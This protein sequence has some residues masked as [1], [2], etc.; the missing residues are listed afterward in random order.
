VRPARTCQDCVTPRGDE[1]L[2][3]VRYARQLIHTILS[4][5]VYIMVYAWN[6]YTIYT[7]VYELQANLLI[8][9][10][11]T[12]LLYLQHIMKILE[13]LF[14]YYFSCFI[15]SD[16]VEN[17][18]VSI[19][20]NIVIGTSRKTLIYSVYQVCKFVC[21]IYVSTFLNGSSKHLEGTFYGS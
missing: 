17:R 15:F 3:T 9:V 4:N 5:R 7:D 2:V 18:T 13:T 16:F 12:I 11:N 14:S 21:K 20:F 8:K 19:Y 10:I 6:S 1:D